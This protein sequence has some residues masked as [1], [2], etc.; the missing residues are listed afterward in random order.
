MLGDIAVLTG[1]RLI[2]EELGIKIEGVE[3]VDVAPLLE[4]LQPQGRQARLPAL[5]PRLDP[6]IPA[7]SRGLPDVAE[8]V[9]Y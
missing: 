4:E 8:C 1:G 5:A 9:S 7:G 3:L 2:A 6:V